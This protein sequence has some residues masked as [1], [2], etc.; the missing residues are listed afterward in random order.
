MNVLIINQYAYAPFH[1]GG[2]RHFMLAR[3]LQRH[4]HRTLIVSTSFFHKSQSETRLAAGEKRRLEDVE[5]V[6]FLWVR[7]PAYRGNGPGRMRNMISFAWQIAASLALPADFVPDV[8][9]SSSPQ[10]LS[11]L[12]AQHL[13]RRLGVP[14]VFEI[15]D[16]WPQTFVDLKTWPSWHPW[17]RIL[18]LIQRHLYRRADHVIT[19]LPDAAEYIIRHGG[20]KEAITWITNGID[21]ANLSAPSPQRP[22]PRPFVLMHAGVHTRSTGLDQALDA[23]AILKRQGLGDDIRLVLLGDGPDKDRHRRRAARENLTNVEFLDPVPRREVQDHLAGA[24]GFLL[25]RA[26]SPVHRWG[27]SPHK[28]ADYFAAGRP[29][30]FCVDSPWN[31]V[32]NVGAGVTAECGRAESLAAAIAELAETGTSGRQIMADRGRAY[33]MQDMDITILGE[34]LNSVLTSVASPEMIPRKHP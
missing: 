7:T 27:I 24:D 23:A 8:I 14:H 31:P 11:S 6:R 25:L 13:A 9:Y 26:P 32:Q 4:G 16:L 21:V 29:V 28:L 19:T 3:E 33:L 15:R 1:H 22:A 2:T 17:I 5:G 12:S 34:R 30:V 10:L 18:D 20:R